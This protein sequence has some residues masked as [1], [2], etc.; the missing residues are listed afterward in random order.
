MDKVL[1]KKDYIWMQYALMLAYVAKKNGEVPVGAIL[2]FNDYIIGTGFNCSIKN[3]DPTAHAEM[4][5]LKEGGKILKNYRLYNTTLYITLEPCLMCLGAIIHSRIS[6]LVL[7]T[8]Y[9]FKTNKIYNT[10]NIFTNLKNRIQIDELINCRV[11][12]DLIKNFFKNKR[13]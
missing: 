3:N 8:K 9:Q 11:Y 6:R 4:I 10:N 7:G 5:A 12:T 1:G 2:V 13:C